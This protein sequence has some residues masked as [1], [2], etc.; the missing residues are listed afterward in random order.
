M[1][2]FNHQGLPILMLEKAELHLYEY[3]ENFITFVIYIQEYLHWLPLRLFPLT[4]GLPSTF[5]KYMAF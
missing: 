4:P 1:A 2:F 5:L 3:T